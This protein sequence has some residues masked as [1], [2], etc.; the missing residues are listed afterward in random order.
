M[1]LAGQHYSPRFVDGSDDP[2]RG[3]NDQ[4]I[5]GWRHGLCGL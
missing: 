5:S 2:V 1:P 3:A 4:W